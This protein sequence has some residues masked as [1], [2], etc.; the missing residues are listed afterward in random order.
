MAQSPCLCWT[1][2]QTLGPLL[3][4]LE[5]L[6]VLLLLSLEHQSLYRQR[7]IAFA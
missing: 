7:L 1:L 6:T 5:G 2:Q 4:L 3:E